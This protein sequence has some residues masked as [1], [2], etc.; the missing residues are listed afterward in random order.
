MKRRVKEALYINV[1]KNPMNKDRIGT[2]R[3][4]VQPLPP[5]LL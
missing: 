5:T 1:E 2:E 3:N 4:L